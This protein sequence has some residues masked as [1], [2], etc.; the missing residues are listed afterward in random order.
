MEISSKWATMYILA[1]ECSDSSG[2]RTVLVSVGVSFNML[3]YYNESV[4]SPRI[5][6]K[7]IFLLSWS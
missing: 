6:L 1:F 2:L 5:Y 3:M 4:T 7:S